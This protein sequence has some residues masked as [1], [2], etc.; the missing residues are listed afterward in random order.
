M[1]ESNVQNLLNEVQSVLARR[2]DLQS[3]HTLVGKHPKQLP[4]EFLV[5]R[6]YIHRLCVFLAD[7]TRVNRLREWFGEGSDKIPWQAK[8]QR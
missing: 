8:D 3:P 1:P 7:G 6:F 4:G 2:L 5:E